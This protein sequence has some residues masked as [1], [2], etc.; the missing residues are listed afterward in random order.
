MILKENPFNFGSPLYLN[1]EAEKVDDILY[2]ILPDGPSDS[3]K[4]IVKP[5]YDIDTVLEFVKD[6]VPVAVY[7]EII[8]ENDFKV[9][10]NGYTHKDC[11]HYWE[12]LHDEFECGEGHWWWETGCDIDGDVDTLIVCEKFEK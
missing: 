8:V 9:I 3:L 10:E 4:I 5:G 6:Y 11:I 12:K 1:L 7:Y 2:L